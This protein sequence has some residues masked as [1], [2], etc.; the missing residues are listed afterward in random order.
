MTGLLEPALKR[1]RKLWRDDDLRRHTIRRLL[2]PWTAERRRSA[3]AGLSRPPYLARASNS[4]VSITWPGVLPLLPW[5]G[6][7]AATGS[8]DLRLAAA[9]LGVADLRALPWTATFKDPEDTSA[10]H[11]F[12]WLLPWVLE[13]SRLRADP[14]A[15]AALV[16][17]AM[18]SWIDHSGSQLFGPAWQSYTV[19]ER[20]VNWTVAALALARPILEDA[21]VRASM[22]GQLAYL[23]DH[24]EYHGE[25]LTG[26]HLSNDGRGLYVAGIV[27]NDGPSVALGRAILLEE[28]RRL[29]EEPWFV[30]EGSSHYQFLI[31]RNYLEALWFADRI[32]DHDLVRTLEPAV[33]NMVEGCR[34]FLIRGEG[35]WQIPLFGD[36]SP[37][38]SPEWLLGV[39]CG[40]HPVL[41]AVEG[42]WEDSAPRPVASREWGRVEAHAWTLFAHVNPSGMPRHHAHQDTGAFVAYYDGHPVMIDAG[43]SSY[44]DTPEGRFGRDWGAHS[45]CVVDGMNPAPNWH[46]AYS[47]REAAVL[48]GNLPVLATGASAMTVTHGGFGRR[49]GIGDHRRVAEIRDNTLVLAE[50]IEGQGRHRIDLVLHVPAPPVEPGPDLRFDF[51]SF[52]LNVAAAADLRDRAVY[53]ASAHDRRFGWRADR[54]GAQTPVTT[55]VFRG[56]VTLPWSGFTALRID[57]RA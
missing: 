27:A 4:P 28:Q 26:N 40:A 33:M 19:A 6:P 23:A 12:A 57:P 13:Q 20:L 47:E 53:C 51:G 45:T 14:D 15:A 18:R 5:G 55:I 9:T 46:W 44:C 1:V 31:T 52:T 3:A 39:A 34:F 2:R 32:G 48:T 37:D 42:V 16:S 36:I 24:L 38:C 49:N 29:C 25:A 22:L 35:G 10:L 41:G 50:T 7:G 21:D 56:E 54:Y 17:A 43:R 30:R 11:R 8:F